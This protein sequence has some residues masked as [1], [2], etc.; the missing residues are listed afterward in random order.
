VD[1][2]SA[3]TGE[4][5]ARLSSFDDIPGDGEEAAA[6]AIDPDAR[7]LVSSL[8][9]LSRRLKEWRRALK[10]LGG[11]AGVDLEPDSQ[12][13]LADATAALPGVVCAVVPGAGGRDALACLHVSSSTARRRVVA[14]WESRGVAALDVRI[15]PFGEGA[16]KED[17]EEEG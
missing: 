7:E 3:R 9:E 13:E 10:E 2:L 12:G 16:R 15:V 14:M 4:E 6:S 5:W 8:A 1:F 17:L 11:A